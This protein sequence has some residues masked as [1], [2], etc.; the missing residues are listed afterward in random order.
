MAYQALYRTYRPGTFDEV[1]GQEYIVRTLQNAVKYN[2]IAHAYL[3]CGPRGTGK[4]SIARILA[5]AVNCESEEKPCNQCASCKMI[6]EGTH[7]DVVEIDGASYG[8]VENTR[9]IIDRVKYAPLQGKYKIY[10][11]DEVHMLSNNAFNSLLKTLEEPPAHAIFI[12]A[13]TDPLK[14]LPTIV[15][16]CQRF[17]FG[18]VKTQDISNRI[19]YILNNE[20]I[21]YEK[22]AA[23]EVAVLADGGMRD[24]LSI[25]DQV[26]A[27]SPEK[28]TL[29]AVYKI[30]GIASSSTKYQLLKEVLTNRT[31]EMLDLSTQLNDIGTDIQRLTDDL[32]EILKECVIYEATREQAFLKHIEKEQAEDLLKDA[33]I[34][35]MLEMIDILNEARNQ[36]RFSVNAYS[37][38]EVALLKMTQL[39][40]KKENKQR[41]VE[42]KQAITEIKE[43]KKEELKQIKPEDS[44]AKETDLEEVLRLL[45]GANKQSRENINSLWININ[46]Y[47]FDERYSRYIRHL[48]EA[49][50]GAAGEDYLLLYTNYRTTADALNEANNDPDFRELLEKAL[51][52]YYKVIGIEKKVYQEAVAQFR[53]RARNNTLPKFEIKQAEQ[54]K[55]KD[56]TEEKLT[57]LLGENSY[58]VIGG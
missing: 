8:N 37:A 41:F 24:A 21:A 32:I 13:T 51:N 43:E 14:V 9:E 40:K 46:N 6:E 7:P 29:E 34:K 52:K 42:E 50:V 33:L 12:L 54:V 55:K 38:F 18:K 47:Q 36:Y 49:A 4:T 53:E 15:S 44:P 58:K 31:K 30:Y 10:I 20:G 25:L 3:F 17:D 28:V 57:S 26:I 56:P 23:E 16:R 45:V 35:E 11:I 5:K 1:V 19:E 48:K 39:F 22:E 27:Y 2:K